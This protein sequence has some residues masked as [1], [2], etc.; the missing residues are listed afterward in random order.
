V[1][2]ETTGRGEQ[3][4]GWRSAG[5][6]VQRSGGQWRGVARSV[7]RGR[8]RVGASS[9]STPGREAEGGTASET[10]VDAG[11]P[12]GGGRHGR[13]GVAQLGMAPAYRRRAGQA[14]ADW[15]SL[16]K[17]AGGGRR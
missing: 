4:G 8:R 2:P 13:A 16:R 7:A 14:R 5:R 12:L 1:W 3:R 10:W 6:G 17:R 11:A 9:R 15:A